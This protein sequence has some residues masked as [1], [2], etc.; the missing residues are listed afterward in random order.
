MVPE[1]FFLPSKLNG[2]DNVPLHYWEELSRRTEKS[3]NSYQ[4][5]IDRFSGGSETEEGLTALV[6]EDMR[7]VGWVVQ[8]HSDHFIIDH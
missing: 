4:V 6:V 2:D 8:R 7:K 3:S 1:P 5:S